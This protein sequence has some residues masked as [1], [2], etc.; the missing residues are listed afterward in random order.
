MT[1]PSFPVC[2]LAILCL[3]VTECLQTHRSRCCETASVFILLVILCQLGVAQTQ[4][5]NGT[6]PL[7]VSC[8]LCVCVCVCSQATGVFALCK[9]THNQ[10]VREK[11]NGSF[12]GNLKLN[13]QRER[14]RERRRQTAA[15]PW[16]TKRTPAYERSGSRRTG[17][18]ASGAPWRFSF[19]PSLICFPHTE[20]F[21]GVSF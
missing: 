8:V 17:M 18:L 9:R 3:G 11:R 14:E 12:C 21:L 6:H 20:P 1:C 10:N 7:C 13:T 4:C 19:L 15:A 16:K 2:F 5:A